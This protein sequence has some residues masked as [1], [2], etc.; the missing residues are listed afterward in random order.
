NMDIE[1]DNNIVKRGWSDQIAVYGDNAWIHHNNIEDGQDMGITIHGSGHKVEF[2]HIENQ[3][4][5]GIYCASIHTTIQNNTLGNVWQRYGKN[6]TRPSWSTAMIL[7][8]GNIKNNIVEKNR[9]S[10]SSR[11]PSFIKIKAND[12][13]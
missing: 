8:K 13:R 10:P 9:I 12:D 4:T 2:N 6:R 5:A 3:G 1:I 7:I 11:N